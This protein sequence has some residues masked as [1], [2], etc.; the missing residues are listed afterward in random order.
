MEGHGYR[1]PTPHEM[2]QAA[3]RHHVRPGSRLAYAWALRELGVPRAALAELL[4]GHGF[5]APTAQAYARTVWQ[6]EP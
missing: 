2:V 5:P 6:N 1:W 4:I 3:A